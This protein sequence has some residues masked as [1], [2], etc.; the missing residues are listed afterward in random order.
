MNNVNKAL[1]LLLLIQAII[2]GV[3]YFPNEEEATKVAPLLPDFDKAAVGQVRIEDNEGN[4]LTVAQDQDG[5]WVLP[6]ADDFPVN[7]TTVT[8]LLDKIAGVQ[9]NRLITRS[10]TS[11]RRLQV[12]S[13]EFNRLVTLTQGDEEIK[14]YI[15]SSGG[16]NATHARVEGEDEVY[17]VSNLSANDANPQV[18]TWINT[19]YF[20]TPVADVTSLTLQNANGTFEFSHT[21]DS[22]WQLAGQGTGEIFNDSAFQTML[23]QATQ[24]RMSE[25]LGKTDEESYG[26]SAPTATITITVRQLVATPLPEAPAVSAEST[27]EATSEATQEA[28]ATPEV[29]STPSAT[30][31]PVYEEKTY[32]LVL[33]ANLVDQNGYVVKSSESE[34]YALISTVAAEAFTNK[35]RENFVMV[36]TATPTPLASETPLPTDTLEASPTIVATATIEA[37]PTVEATATI[38]PTLEATEES[39]ELPTEEPASASATPRPTATP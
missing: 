13:D 33:G 10:E 35:T 38:A 2:V 22:T 4:S 11:H 3:L 26:M 27:S 28:T 24:L 16:A 1:V 9:T 29:T 30:P 8:T 20:T 15:G 36:P 39:T 17:L 21:G 37:S 14:L 12:A 34:Y 23:N 5:N 25:P 32:I 18:S 6:E 19:T 7:V 31:E